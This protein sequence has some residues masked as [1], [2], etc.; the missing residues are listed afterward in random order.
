MAFNHC[1]PTQY[2]EDYVTHPLLQYMKPLLFFWKT[3]QL[4]ENMSILL[5]DRGLPP[6][7]ENM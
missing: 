5:S 4:C 7:L 1:G 3:Q 2:R 6:F